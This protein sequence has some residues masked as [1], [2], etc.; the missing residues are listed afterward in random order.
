MFFIIN[1]MSRLLNL[2]ESIKNYLDAPTSH[3]VIQK[4]RGRP[5]KRICIKA[6]S[7]SQ[8][9]P[10]LSAEV[11]EYNDVLVCVK[12]HSD[13]LNNIVTQLV[14]D[15]NPNP[16][17]CTHISNPSMSICQGYPNSDHQFCGCGMYL[18]GDA[19][20]ICRKGLNYHPSPLLNIDQE[21]EPGSSRDY[22]EIDVEI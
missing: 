8:N 12:R 9:V 11:E 19:E 20:C 21:S 7:T 5:K 3:K 2:A 22:E 13:E 14:S 16:R 1:E 10:F 17:A 4:R 15:E 18:A 6:P